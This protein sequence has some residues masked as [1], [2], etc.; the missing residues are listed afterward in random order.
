[1]WVRITGRRAR[2]AGGLLAGDDWTSGESGSRAAASTIFLGGALN[3]CCGL[4]P[5]ESTGSEQMEETTGVTV[6]MKESEC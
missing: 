2:P 4:A 3:E 5:L 1:L 6:D